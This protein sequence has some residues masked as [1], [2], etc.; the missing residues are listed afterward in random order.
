MRS[1]AVAL[2][3]LTIFA[4][5][6][7]SSLTYTDTRVIVDIGSP[8]VEEAANFAMSEL[9]KLSDSGVYESLTL[10]SV[11][12]AEAQ[13]G[14]F[15]DNLFLKLTMS[16]PHLENG[17]TASRHEV[18]VMR[19]LKDGVRSFAI[20]EFPRMDEDA[21]EAFWIEKVERHR[22]ARERS[23][24]AMEEQELRRSL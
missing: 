20:D 12:A 2:L 16:S 22:A 3:I 10:V 17:M 21:I 15:H 14:V 19:H 24:A 5:K 13:K 23:F 1:L 11:D 8:D 6:Q 4:R 18:I 7:A 9:K